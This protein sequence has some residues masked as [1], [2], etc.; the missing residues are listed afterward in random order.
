M[1]THGFF[2]EVARRGS[3]IATSQP[4]DSPQLVWVPDDVG[5][6]QEMGVHLPALVLRGEPRL[7]VDDPREL[8]PAGARE[9]VMD[10]ALHLLP[11]HLPDRPVGGADLVTV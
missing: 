1:I 11:D 3:S 4:A 7:G 10:V 9:M 2:G 5:R 8:G 6:H